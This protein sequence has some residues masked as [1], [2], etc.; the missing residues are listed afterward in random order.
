MNKQVLQKLSLI[1]YNPSIFKDEQKN[2]LQVQMV[3]PVTDCQT[4]FLC[5]RFS[6]KCHL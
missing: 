6:L 5:Q 1:F 4:S 3:Q 2:I